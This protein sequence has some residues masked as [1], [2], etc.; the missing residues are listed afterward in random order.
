[1]SL[2]VVYTKVTGHVVGAVRMIGGIPPKDPAELVGDA[3]PIRLNVGS[4]LVELS[5]PAEDLAVHEVDDQP[6]VFVHPLEYGVELV[7]STPKPALTRLTDWQVEVTLTTSTLIVTI[8]TA[9]TNRATPVM[10]LVSGGQD[11]DP[12]T[13]QIGAGEDT[14]ELPISVTTGDHAVLVLVAGWIGHLTVEGTRQ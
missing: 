12:V 11:N 2:Y 7:D 3:L 13:R 8:P 6:D 4:D 10:A 1:M 14:V 9:D 5:L